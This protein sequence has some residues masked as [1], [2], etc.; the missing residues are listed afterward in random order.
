MSVWN[1]IQLWSIPTSSAYLDRRA[2]LLVREIQVHS[3][4]IDQIRNSIQGG[5][6]YFVQNE[7]FLQIGITSFGSVFGCE[8]NMNAGTFCSTKD[9]HEIFQYLKGFTRT[10]KYLPWIQSTTG[11]MFGIWSTESFKWF[12]LWLTLEFWRKCC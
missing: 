2:S 11:V 4:K 7:T 3:N 5:P 6:L 1:N 10:S 12:T 9:I 8:V